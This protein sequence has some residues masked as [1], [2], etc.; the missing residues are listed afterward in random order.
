VS[1]VVPSYNSAAYLPATLA[2]VTGQTYRDWEVVLVDDGSADGPAGVAKRIIPPGRLTLVRQARRGPAAARNRG[3]Q[4]ARGELIAFL[5]SD[6]LWR[7][8][9][10]AVQ[11]DWLDAHPA[12]GL[13]A[14]H[15]DCCTEAGRPSPGGFFGFG[16]QSPMEGLLGMHVFLPC[17]VMI[18]RGAFLDAGGFREEWASGEDWELWVRLLH[19]GVGLAVVGRVLCTVRRRA[20]SASRDYKRAVADK[21][22]LV[23]HLRALVGPELMNGTRMH[24]LHRM[25]LEGGIGGALHAGRV[26]EAVGFER[27]RQALCAGEPADRRYFARLLESFNYHQ[28][29]EGPVDAAELKLWRRRLCELAALLRADQQAVE[30][31]LSRFEARQGH[32]GAALRRLLSAGVS[33]ESLKAWGVGLSQG[34]RHVLQGS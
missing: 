21:L 2:S 29:A 27:R 26:H 14:A 34:L 8:D 17:S 3:V 10:L 13:V 16:R 25:I 28:A 1:V 30:L 19:N 15:N 5:D 24:V 23:A 33:A 9:K 4:V 11:T 7:P 18:R 12:V 31:A 32:A 6:D 22:S 20:T